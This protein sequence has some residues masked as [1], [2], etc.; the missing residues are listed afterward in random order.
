MSNKLI[1]QFGLALMILLFSTLVTWYEGSEILD[2]PSEWKYSTPFTHLFYGGVN[3]SNDISR[4][5]YY[6]Y[7]AKFK[8]IN[9][10][11]MLISSVYL[12]T[13]FA[14][15]LLKQNRKWFSWFTISLGMLLLLFS[16]SLYSSPTIGG[17][18]IFY[19]SL[20]I[21]ILYIGIT[22]IFSA[23]SRR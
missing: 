4:L 18:M 7:A 17:R 19:V 13:L 14:Y 1:F 6:V 23:Q 5:D 21:G 8:P 11:I 20:S 10:I 9:P 15:L 2:R 12:L 22:A 3:D 16:I